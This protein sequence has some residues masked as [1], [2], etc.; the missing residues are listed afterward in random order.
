[1]LNLQPEVRDHSVFNITTPETITLLYSTL[2]CQWTDFYL[3]LFT[4]AETFS[5]KLLNKGVSL[6]AI[7]TLQLNVV[8][9]SPYKNIC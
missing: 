4:Q 9:F 1:M 5:Q 6:S 3:W 8:H 2:N 7:L